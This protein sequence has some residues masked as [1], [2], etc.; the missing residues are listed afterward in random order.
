MEGIQKAHEFINSHA[1]YFPLEIR[2]NLRSISHRLNNIAKYK[3]NIDHDTKIDVFEETLS[4]IEKA[5]KALEDYIDK[6]NMLN[7]KL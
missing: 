5:K 3:D 2:E 6:F 1:I 7:Y 4:I